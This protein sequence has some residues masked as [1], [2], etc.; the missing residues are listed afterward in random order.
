VV[1]AR[2]FSRLFDDPSFA[3]GEQIGG[4]VDASHVIGREKGQIVSAV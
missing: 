1:L 3:S 2:F 4:H